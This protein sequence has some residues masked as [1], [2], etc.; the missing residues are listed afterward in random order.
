MT[1]ELYPQLNV[2]LMDSD[3]QESCLDNSDRQISLVTNEI[4]N[5]AELVRVGGLCSCSRDFNRRDIFAHP[6]KNPAS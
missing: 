1:E 3:R 4:T 6:I 2:I 5:S